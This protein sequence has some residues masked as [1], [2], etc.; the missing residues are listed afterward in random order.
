MFSVQKLIVLIAIIWYIITAYYSIGYIH[1]DEHYQI[2]EFAGYIDGTNTADDLAW[3]FNRKIRPATQPVVAYFIFKV[4]DF[5]SINNPYNQALVLRILTAFLAVFTILFF[6]KSVKKFIQE[7]YWKILLILSYFI[8]FLPF[9]NI[10]FSSETGSGLLF[11][12]A[13][14]L[15]IRNVRK[16]TNFL[17]IGLV[18]GLSFLFRYQIAIAALGLVLWMLFVRKEK[19]K[20]LLLIAFSGLL[21]VFL[22]YLLDS[23]FYGESVLVF[24]NYL[25]VNL[26]EGAA[27][28][29]STRPWYH[30]IQLLLYYP[31][32]FIGV[33]ILL[34]FLLL[35][36][37]R[38]TNIFVWI[39]LPFFII[40][41]VISHK[42]LR[43]L[44]PLINFIP[45]VFIL[46]IQ[47]VKWH[48]LSKKWQLLL[49]AVIVV[50]LFLN[51]GA[52][53]VSSLI[54]AGLSS[55]VKITK[56]IYD[57]KREQPIDLYSFH[58]SNPYM[59]WGLPT[60]FYMEEDIRYKEVKSYQSDHINLDAIPL[61]VVLQ[62]DL[63]TE[64]VK[65]FLKITGFKKITTGAF[66]PIV[67]LYRSDDNVLLLYGEELLID[68]F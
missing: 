47:A 61:F 35:A 8:W 14:S 31:I 56:K 42:E 23:W 49:K 53:F 67:P 65:D 6:N 48:K 50:L 44:F 4:C 45:V 36:Y 21:V 15:V 25:K 1:A 40:H 20:N 32:P 68:K 64:E 11:L 57:F 63:A 28:S 18:L 33:L 7:K 13:V 38:K 46:F 12:I 2:I 24:W 17:L 62:K 58:N 16:P 41:S 10:R 52:L 51:L 29:F 37:Q 30:Y 26:I 3:E 55:R 34:S 5:F 39:V 43:F 19:L 60:H 27:A 9:I 22:G 59:P 54:P 66:T